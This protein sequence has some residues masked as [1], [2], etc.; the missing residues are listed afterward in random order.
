MRK[1]DERLNRINLGAAK[2]PITFGFVARVV[3]TRVSAS[4]VMSLFIGS[5]ASQALTLGNG[6]VFIEY[7]VKLLRTGSPEYIT[8][9]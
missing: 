3:R 6:S 4:I 7:R 8:S 9:V 5:P 2:L 1:T